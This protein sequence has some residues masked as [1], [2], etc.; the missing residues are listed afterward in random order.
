M[1]DLASRLLHRDALMLIIDKPAGLPVHGG[2]RGG[3]TLQAHLDELR[4]GLPR[5]PELAH[6]LDRDTSGCLV[7]G[8]HRK[9]LAELGRLFAEGKVEKVYWAVAV[10]R[11]HGESGV[12]ELPLKKLERKFGWRMVVDEHGLASAT[13]WRVLGATDRLCWVECRPLTGRTHQ[14]RAHMAAIGCPLVGDVIY[15]KGTGTL[16]GDHL[17]L[18]SRSITVPLNP[19]KPAITATAPVP[20]HMRALLAECG[21]EQ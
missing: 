17:H 21:W 9:A 5:M 16:A 6:R 19:R 3:D 11:P 10:G 13:Q 15:G 14:I 20:E 7:L 2:E 18:H 1:L 4:F 8:R 12:V